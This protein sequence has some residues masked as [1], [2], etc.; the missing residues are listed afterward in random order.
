MQKKHLAIILISF[1]VL[2]TGL[3]LK[4]NFKLSSNLLEVFDSVDEDFAVAAN[5]FEKD[6]ET[7]VS[8]LVVSDD[9]S[10][11]KSVSKSLGK[12]LKRNKLVTKI[13]TQIPKELIKS[14][15][16]YY[17]KKRQFLLGQNQIDKIESKNFDFFY[18]RALTKLYAPMSQGLESIDKDPL[19]LFSSFYE[20]YHNPTNLELDNGYLTVNKDG[21]GVFQSAVV[22]SKVSKALSY[23]TQKKEELAKKDIKLLFHS[24]SFY[25]E[26][27]KVQAVEESR[28]FCAIS[29]LLV[30]FLF[31]LFFRS[32]SP[33]LLSAGII[34]SSIC[35][36]FG[37]SIFIF[38]SMHFLSLLF[39]LSIVGI[40][41]DYCIHYFIKEMSPDYTNGG[42]VY[43]SI[44]K[45]LFY[46][47]MTTLIGFSAFMFTP[48]SILRQ[49][50]VFSL[51]ALSFA[52]LLVRFFLVL[53]YKN[54]TESTVEKRKIYLQ[55][56]IISKNKKLSWTILVALLLS[57]SYSIYSSKFEDDIRNL[58]EEENYLRVMEDELK[59]LVGLRDIYQSII[60]KADSFEKLLIK[61]E[62]IRVE[63]EK[64]KISYKALSQWV[65]S[66]SKQALSEK[67]YKAL[68]PV[69]KK[70]YEKL[71][72]D[73]ES[74]KSSFNTKE[75]LIDFNSFNKNVSK[76]GMSS[77]YL[78]RMN[79]SEYSIVSI[80]SK[81][82]KGLKNNIMAEGVFY[83]D[84][85]NLI[86][87][88]MKKFREI[89]LMTFVLFL[90]LVLAFLSIKL[91]IAEAFLILFPA[92]FSS[93]VAIGISSLMAPSLNLF[94]LLGGV[95]IF[96]LSVDYSFFY[97]FSRAQNELVA[98]S[99]SL[100]V[101]T[102]I[103]SFGMLGL[104]S[105]TSVCSFGLCVVIGIILAWL[106]CPLSYFSRN[107]V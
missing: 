46:G 61:E 99:V 69:A 19:L 66:R 31:Y 3:F 95:L 57:A 21:S 84:K 42:E 62:K 20:S 60:I 47:L 41:A 25:G 29:F 16:T 78:G 79:E 34:L 10:V 4:T 98:R 81:V 87:R 86:K 15:K 105:T 102:T 54:K 50:A 56:K 38:G 8:I 76:S 24:V 70:L 35:F 49:F 92:L 107:T 6:L 96:C 48:L 30:A 75:S 45:P 26:H 39:S 32:F 93:I 77:S 90:A 65:P 17:F 52:Y 18:Q 83:Y 74:L 88:D 40:I 11:S 103:S 7:R 91:T 33:I 106:I 23:L 27:A 104:S 55:E 53:F 80:F 36:G 9:L 63:L 64:N 100:S 101:L 97:F 82:S 43:D 28:V 94:H 71:G 12:S 89:L 85:L 13:N 14:L 2:T 73:K 44:R 22:S 67:S 37:V 1:L 51:V 59:D 68:I 58:G 5:K 72:M